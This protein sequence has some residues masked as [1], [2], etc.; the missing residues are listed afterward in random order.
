MTRHGE[1]TLQTLAWATG[2]ARRSWGTGRRRWRDDRALYMMQR[3]E[4]SHFEQ[5]LVSPCI[6][7]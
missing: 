3:S 5:E 4:Y 6:V 1:R 7:S 2:T